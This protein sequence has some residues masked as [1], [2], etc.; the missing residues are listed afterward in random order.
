MNLKRKFVGCLL[1]LFGSAG[2]LAA[3]GAEDEACETIEDCSGDQVCNDGVCEDPADTGCKSNDECTV[4]GEVCVIPDGA[5]SGACG[6]EDKT[7]VYF[8]VLVK[9]VSTGASCTDTSFGFA[10]PGSQITYVRL[11]NAETNDVIAYGTAVSSK[12]EGESDF[13]DVE[14]VLNGQAPT[15][16]DGNDYCVA[17]EEYK[18]KDDKTVANGAG[19]RADSGVAIGCEGEVYVTFKADDVA[20][21]LDESQVV[22]VGEYNTFCDERFKGVDNYEVYLCE[23]EGTD[24]SKLDCTRKISGAEALTGLEKTSAISLPEAP[25]AE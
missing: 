7:P 13:K 17:F 9:D 2:L 15:L 16:A 19:F 5:E 12:I 1:V 23:G 8:T 24:V 11:E 3:C 14:G 18:T 10:T 4:A 21:A 20:I 25:A 22:R 6:I